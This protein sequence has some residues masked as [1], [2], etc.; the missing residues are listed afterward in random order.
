MSMDRY[1]REWLYYNFAAE[2][3]HTKNFVVDFIPLKLNFIKKRKKSLFE[4]PF[5]ELR[6]NVR[7]Q[8]ISRWKALGRYCIHHN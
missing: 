7:T 4:P 1:I 3:F 6:S 8:Y 2:S 5:T